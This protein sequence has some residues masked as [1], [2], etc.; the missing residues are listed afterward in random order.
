MITK[1]LSNFVLRKKKTFVVNI[2][3]MLSLRMRG[4]STPKY[5][6]KLIKI[7]ILGGTY[8]PGG[9]KSAIQY[10]I[11]ISIKQLSIQ[12]VMYV[13]LEYIS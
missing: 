8:R 11:M 5:A 12:I 2:L 6:G 3:G 4:F 13:L 1:E 10:D 7:L 9:N